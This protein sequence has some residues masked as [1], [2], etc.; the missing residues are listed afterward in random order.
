MGE[1]RRQLFCFSREWG[2]AMMPATRFISVAVNSYDNFRS[3]SLLSQIQVSLL[4]LKLRRLASR[5]Q[6]CGQTNKAKSNV[7]HCK[8]WRITKKSAHS[9]FQSKKNVISVD[10]RRVIFFSFAANCFMK[11]KK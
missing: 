3:L 8:R 9:L 10:F 7:H 4:T 6:F 5:K 1:K 11:A 2:M